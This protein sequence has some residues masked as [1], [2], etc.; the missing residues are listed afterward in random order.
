MSVQIETGASPCQYSL[1]KRKI[2]PITVCEVD[3]NRS[4][5]SGTPVK[6]SQM[7][8]HKQP[9]HVHKCSIKDKEAQIEPLSLILS[10]TLMYF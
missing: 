9:K 8:K 7:Y 4:C 10:D 1:S 6:I 3:A 5:C 2:F